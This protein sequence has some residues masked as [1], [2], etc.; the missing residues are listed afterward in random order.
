MN[1]YQVSVKYTKEFQDGTL[2]RVTEP[3]IVNAIS[4]TDAEALIYQEVGEFIRG[5]F[6]V[7]AIAKQEIADI[8]KYDDSDVWN[9][10]KI[11]Y[12]MEDENSGKEKKT[13]Q[14][15]L[16]SAPTVKEADARIIESLAG[17]F[18]HNYE[19]SKVEKTKIVD[20]ITASPVEIPYHMNQTQ[21]NNPNVTVTVN[22]D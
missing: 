15:F 12:M 6:I 4:F 21:A 19:V 22:Q 20:I 13:N 8:F 18:L 3:Y 5:E 10:V 16:V 17:G 2:K 11:S 1:W 9:K 7:E 14:V